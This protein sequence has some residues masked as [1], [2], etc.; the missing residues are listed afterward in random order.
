MEKTSIYTNGKNE[1]LKMPDFNKGGKSLQVKKKRVEARLF[2][3]RNIAS[4]ALK[5][6]INNEYEG[7]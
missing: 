5:D 6:F 3:L 4:E 2:A 7:I 1:G